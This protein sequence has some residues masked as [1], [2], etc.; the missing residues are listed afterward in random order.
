MRSQWGREGANKLW[1]AQN[2]SVMWVPMRHTTVYELDP[3]DG[4]LR[5]HLDPDQR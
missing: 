2:Y 4:T 1:V 3:A 5:W